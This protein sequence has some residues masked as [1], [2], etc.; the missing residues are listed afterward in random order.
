MEGP[1]FGTPGASA[2]DYS[3]GFSVSFFGFCVVFAGGFCWGGG[4]AAGGRYAGVGA[5]VG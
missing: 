4:G 5:A 2:R 1:G 3:L